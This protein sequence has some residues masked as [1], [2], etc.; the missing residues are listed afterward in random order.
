MR[1]AFISTM[2]GWPWGGS[3]EL[4][5]QAATQL[6]QAGHD[7]RASVVY[8]PRLSDKLTVLKQHGIR[9]E[10]HP[11]PSYLAGPARH[12]VNRLTLSTRRSYRRLQRFNPDL[13]II[14]Q[15][16]NSGGF[17]WAQICRE[18]AIPYVMIVHCNSEHW[19]FYEQPDEAVA[20]YTGARRIFCVSRS[21]LDLLRLQVGEPLLNAEV[22]RNPYNVSTEPAPAWPD[23]SGGWRL[24]CVARIDLAAK[25]QDLLL[26]T[27][28]RPEWRD[29][30]VEL[31]FFGTGPHELALRRMAGMLQ[32]NN[33]HFRGHVTD[34]RAIWAQNHLLVLPSRYEGLPL[35]LVEAMWCGRPSVVT[36]VGGNA[37]LCVDN[38]TGFVAPAATV[39]SFADALQRAWERREEWAQLGHAARTR[40]ETVIPKDPVTVFCE[41]LKAYAAAKSGEAPAG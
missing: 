13:V 15:A 1:F 35:A 38:E 40:V 31:N 3:E 23:E 16:H 26:Q 8:R 5:S 39:S 11:S 36:D 9:I 34:I 37:E 18:A 28:A 20:S 24:A 41:R 4:W 14:S 21:N 12:I 22:V 10:G 2:Q 27:L 29:R 30:A 33:V 19:W 6:K 17:E 32:V 7:V 25:G